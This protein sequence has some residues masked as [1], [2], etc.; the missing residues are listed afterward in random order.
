MLDGASR[1]SDAKL[2]WKEP[3]WFLVSAATLL[4]VY[5]P[6]F[7]VRYGMHNDY[8]MAYGTTG[9]EWHPE[10]TTL[11]VLGRPLNALLASVHHSLLHGVGDL[12]WSRAIGFVISLAIAWV[13][14]R[15]LTRR[16][17]VPAWVSACTIVIVFTT[18][19][20]QLNLIW[21]EQLVPNIITVALAL[22][23]YAAYDR[24]R[25]RL[26]AAPRAGWSL[27]FAGM[28][29][30]MA[31]LMIYPATATFFLFPSFCRLL[32]DTNRRATRRAVTHD[33]VFCVVGMGAYFVAVKL[34]ILPLI[35]AWSADLS[36]ALLTVDKDK[37]FAISLDLGQNWSQFRALTKLALSSWPR[38]DGRY[39]NRGLI[40]VGVAA[41]TMV[42]Y[43]NWRAEGREA[44]VRIGRH[45]LEVAL[46]AAMVVGVVLAPILAPAGRNAGYRMLFPYAAILGVFLVWTLVFRQPGRA[47]GPNRFRALLLVLITC[48]FAIFGQVNVLNTVSNAHLELTYVRQSLAC[49]I[50]NE[51]QSLVF[52]RPHNSGV[53]LD[54]PLYGEFRQLALNYDF[55]PGIVEAAL[56]EMGCSD[57]H[58]PERMLVDAGRLPTDL[59]RRSDVSIVDLT[60]AQ[61]WRD[62]RFARLGKTVPP[63]AAEAR[64]DRPRHSPRNLFDWDTTGSSFWQASGQE[65]IALTLTFHEP[66]EIASYALGAGEV[67][68]EYMPSAWTLEGLQ[69][70]GEWRELDRQEDQTSWSPMQRRVYKLSPTDAYL[71]LRLVFPGLPGDRVLKVYE[72]GFE[73]R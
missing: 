16:L 34:V 50:H 20:W 27:I 72:M 73:P 19:A 15:F 36:N 6:T 53:L 69:R 46:F 54:Q 32:F 71:Q 24:G 61:L 35:A 67:D 52:V 41:A 11:L 58:I 14:F 3:Y 68:A 66:L 21:A 9:F 60:G 5:L 28:L 51:H 31:S 22:L 43:T 26:P 65:P 42:V 4:C 1:N 13:L 56:A 49:Y 44:L 23:A 48:A 64:C 10:S 55:M 63:T 8:N 17:L 18:P 57:V 12:I 7:I 25:Q 47:V 70:S 29:L 45:A 62:D 30:F 33:L 2:T 38:G 40:A 37:R 39:L 59:R